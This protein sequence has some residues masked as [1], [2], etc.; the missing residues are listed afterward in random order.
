MEKY[1]RSSTV[2]TLVRVWR[3]S[4]SVFPEVEGKD[5]VTDTRGKIIA[6]AQHLH[7]LQCVHADTT[8]TNQ[9]SDLD[10]NTE[11][12]DVLGRPA[13]QVFN[14][15][16][17]VAWNGFRCESL[18]T[19]ALEAAKKLTNGEDFEIDDSSV[20]HKSV[21][22]STESGNEI[23]SFESTRLVWLTSPCSGPKRR[24]SWHEWLKVPTFVENS[25]A[26]QI[27]S[28]PIS[29]NSEGNPGKDGRSPPRASSRNPAT[30]AGE[31]QNRMLVAS[32]WKSMLKSGPSRFAL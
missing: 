2:E 18:G 8:L 1:I 26:A 4:L 12:C 24:R 19:G 32:Q 17:C 7:H 11:P 20:T 9:A 3:A 13:Q 27:F 15:R 16:S 14:G 25:R 30:C 10:Q 22:F 5:G 6:P 29:T 21:K 23:R 31:N 28:F